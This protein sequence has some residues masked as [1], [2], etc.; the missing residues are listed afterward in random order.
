[1]RFSIQTPDITQ[2][3]G[4][5]EISILSGEG[6]TMYLRTVP[7]QFDGS[8]GIAFRYSTEGSSIRLPD[9]RMIPL[10]YNAE[11]GLHIVSLYNEAALLAVS[12]DC[13]R[14]FEQ[15]VDEHGTAYVIFETLPGSSVELRSINF[16][17]T[18]VY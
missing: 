7:H 18:D 10:A 1:M 14:L 3:L 8:T 5:F 13:D 2:F 4:Q 16:F 11:S 6:V 9:G 17:E 12:V 15:L